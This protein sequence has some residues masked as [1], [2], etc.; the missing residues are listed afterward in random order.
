MV[1]VTYY[2]S[3]CRA[4]IVYP[5]IKT[6]VDENERSDSRRVDCVLF[7]CSHHM[8]SFRAGINHP[9]LKTI[10]GDIERTD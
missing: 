2:Q 1:S 10:V 5:S 9:S 8:I 3:P 4:G 7:R 6:T